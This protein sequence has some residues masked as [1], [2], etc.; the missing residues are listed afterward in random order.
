MKMRL[1]ISIRTSLL[2]TA[3]LAIA[4]GWLADRHRLKNQV[5]DAAQWDVKQKEKMLAMSRELKRLKPGNAF[6]MPPRQPPIEE[7]FPATP[8]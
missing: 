6:K 8:R 7:Y 2:L 3:L 5:R 4:M 1:Q